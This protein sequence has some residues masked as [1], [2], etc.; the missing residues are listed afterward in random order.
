MEQKYILQEPGSDE[1]GG[2]GMEC[3]VD[4]TNNNTQYGTFIMATFTVQPITG[5][6]TQITPQ[7]QLES[8]I[9]S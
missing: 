1:I 2:D 9:L 8:S 4:Y 6:S 7:I 3:I 5:V